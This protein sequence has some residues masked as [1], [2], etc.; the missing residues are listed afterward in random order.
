MHKIKMTLD[1]KT[2]IFASK[3]GLVVSLIKKNS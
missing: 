1:M 2:E 3:F